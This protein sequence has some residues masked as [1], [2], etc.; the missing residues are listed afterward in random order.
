MFETKPEVCAVFLYRAVVFEDSADRLEYDLD[1][2]PHGAMIHVV[3]FLFL[4]LAALVRAVASPVCRPHADHT[5]AHREELL[6]VLPV[7]LLDLLPHERAGTDDGDPSRKD[8][9][10]V[11]ELVETCLAEKRPDLGD[12][13]VMVDLILPPVLFELFGR[14][15]ILEDKLTPEQLEQYRREYKIDHDPRVTKVGAFLRKT[16]L[17]EL[18]N[19][20]AVFTGRI[21]V[22]G[23]RPLMR[24]EI[25]EKYGEDKEKLLSVRPG[26]IGMW[27]AYGRSNCTYESGERQ[28]KEL[29]Y[30]DHCSVGLDIK[31]VFKTIGGVLKHDG[32]I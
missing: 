7:L 8:R 25:E 18:P 20:W 30:V 3:E 6:L 32:A 31:I 13:G 4:P 5:G 21:S 9:P 19:V 27:A 10:D 15:L 26:M 2:E 17:D 24:Q 1:V 11:G 14:E 23:P 29:Y 12:A 22:I 16:S 28:K